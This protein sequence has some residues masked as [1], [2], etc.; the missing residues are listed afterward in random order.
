MIVYVIVCDDY[1]IIL[2]RAR[3]VAPA[4]QLWMQ[5]EPP[6]KSLHSS[7]YLNSCQFFHQPAN[8][9]GN[10]PLLASTSTSTSFLRMS[11]PALNLS[12]YCSGS[13]FS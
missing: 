5:A 11:L 2:T 12:V 10:G 1:K 7:V 6:E 9:Y 8:Q 3:I 13:Q 4:R